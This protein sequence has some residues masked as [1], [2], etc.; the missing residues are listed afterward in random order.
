MRNCH[1]FQV[2]ERGVAF[3]GKGGYLRYDEDIQICEK[4]LIRGENR[5]LAN[6][7]EIP[8]QLVRHRRIARH[9]KLDETARVT[10]LH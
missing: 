1:Q 10:G 9:G 8:E 6:E 4:I 7:C 5:A 3:K 2:S